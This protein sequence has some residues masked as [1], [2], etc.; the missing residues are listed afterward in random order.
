LKIL[1]SSPHSTPIIL[2]GRNKGFEDPRL[3][4]QGTRVRKI[5]IQTFFLKRPVN[6]ERVIFLDGMGKTYN[7]FEKDSSE[8]KRILGAHC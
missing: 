2:E 1:V 3:E 8:E 4:G 6:Y 7:D 5:S